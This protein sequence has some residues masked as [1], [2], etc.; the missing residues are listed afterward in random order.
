MGIA[1]PATLAALRTSVFNSFNAALQSSGKESFSSKLG[2]VTTFPSSSQFNTY[3]WLSRDTRMREWIG[4]RMVNGVSER[5]YTIRNKKYEKTFG[6]YEDELE[7]NE[8][9]TINYAASIAEQ[10]ATAVT[11][12]DDDLL[13]SLMQNGQ[14]ALAYDGQ[15][16]YDTD[17]PINLD[18]TV[19]GTQSNYEAAAFALTQANFFIARQ[20][21][22]GFKGEDG[23]PLGI[24]P[25]LLVV[26]PA[27]E[28]EAITILKAGSLASGAEN[29]TQGMAAYVVVPE[30]AGQDTTWYLFDTSGPGPQAFIKQVRRAPRLTTKTAN[31]DDNVFW[32]GQYIW[33][34]DTRVGMGYGLWFKAFKGVG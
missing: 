32:D 18:D 12:L 5:V 17:H 30:L 25:S 6:V 11:R 13:I 15:F 16:F 24:R 29:I 27:L 8:K 10:M 28:D 23:R 34:V 9:S 19:A 33:G 20:R 21:M 7:D 14:T 1:T 26:P 3:E 22:M 31:T 2:V 4:P